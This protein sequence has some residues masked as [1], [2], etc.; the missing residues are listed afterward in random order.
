MRERRDEAKRMLRAR[1]TGR[2]V[3][4]IGRGG[5]FEAVRWER[6]D[7]MRRGRRRGPRVK[8]RVWRLESV[9]GRLRGRCT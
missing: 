9:S 5:V 7:E 6:Y 3:G 8:R 1:R 4:I 2:G